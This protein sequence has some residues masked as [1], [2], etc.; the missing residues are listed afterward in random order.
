[1]RISDLFAIVADAFVDN[2]ERDT[3]YEILRALLKGRQE[4]GIE[5]SLEDFKR[6]RR[7]ISSYLALDAY[8]VTLMDRLLNLALEATEAYEESLQDDD[9]DDMIASNFE[10]LA[11]YLRRQHEKTRWLNGCLAVLAMANIV[12][13][14]FNQTTC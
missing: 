14:L 8:E 5:N 4:L 13:T 1:M 6:N 3:L 9:L 2:G 10:N 11:D 7:E 12:V